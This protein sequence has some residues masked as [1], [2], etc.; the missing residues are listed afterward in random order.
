MHLSEKIHSQ[1]RFLFLSFQ[2]KDRVRFMRI[3]SFIQPELCETMP[4]SGFPQTVQITVRVYG[5]YCLS[6]SQRKS[7]LWLVSRIQHFVLESL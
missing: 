6:L 5:F 4:D 3:L 1:R 7:C 2:T